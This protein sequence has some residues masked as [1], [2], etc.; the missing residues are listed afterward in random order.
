MFEFIEIKGFQSQYDSRIDFS[1]GMTAI[2]GRSMEG[3]T[4]ILRAFELIRTNRPLGTSFLYRYEDIVCEVSIGVDGHVITYKKSKKA[5]D[6]EGSKALYIIKYPDGKTKTESVFGSSVPESVSEIIN[7]SNISIQ[8]QLDPY[9][10][11]TSTSGEIAKTINKITGID[12]GD[13]WLKEIKRK[14]SELK[15][16]KEILDRSQEDLKKQISYYSE[17]DLYKEKLIESEQL[18]LEYNNKIRSSNSI[19]DSL[20]YQKGLEVRTKEN[21]TKLTK[22]KALLDKILEVK[23]ENQNFVLFLA[24]INKFLTLSDALIIKKEQ[25]IELLNK[26]NDAFLASA[27]LIKMKGSVKS[28]EYFIEKSVKIE[29]IKSDINSKKDELANVIFNFKTCFVCGSELT[30]YKKIRNSL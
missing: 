22:I 26:M 7:L 9:L 17:V 23:E 8:W 14:V 4:A 21:Q 1:E 11:V 13:E 20:N 12:L 28:I 29:N 2:T 15:T 25:S 5:L 30:D 10:L 18:D 3:K 19:L 27:D 6:K 24:T 16:E